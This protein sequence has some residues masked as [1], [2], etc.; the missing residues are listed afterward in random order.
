LG[1]INAI[2]SHLKTRFKKN[3]D[4]NMLENVLFFGKKMEKSTQ[5]WA[6][7]PSWPP[8]AGSAPRPQVVTPV[9]CFSYFKITTYY[10]KLE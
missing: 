6:L 2:C 4:Q 1:R 10:L 7:K 5:R 9:A 8:A 3:F